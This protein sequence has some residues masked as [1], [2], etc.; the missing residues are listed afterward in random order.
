MHSLS[1][2]RCEYLIKDRL[3]F[4]RAGPQRLVDGAGLLE[5]FRNRFPG[6]RRPDC[7]VQPLALTNNKQSYWSRPARLEL[8]AG[9]TA[10]APS[11]RLS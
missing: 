9:V 7:L 1:D 8:F 4:M 5:R 3:S 11:V 6:D 10:D 2:E